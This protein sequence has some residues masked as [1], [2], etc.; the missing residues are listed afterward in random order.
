[1][2]QILLF[3]VFITGIACQLPSTKKPK[4]TITNTND[5]LATGWYYVTDSTGWK[6]T[7]LKTS[8]E[9]HLDPQPILTAQ[10]IDRME[11]VEGHNAPQPFYLLVMYFDADAAKTWKDATHRYIFRK[12]AFV[13]DNRL[14][15][16][17]TVQSGIDGGVAAINSGTYTKEELEQFKFQIEAER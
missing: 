11:V 4:R 2:K 7:L 10:D 12:L 9:Y 13:I 1:M 5:S 3:L 17:A 14:V 6:R 8:E 15:H 16:V